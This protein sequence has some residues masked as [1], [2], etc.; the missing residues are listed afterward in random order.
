LLV[1]R[2]NVME[3]RELFNVLVVA[4]LQRSVQRL[5]VSTRNHTAA[6]APTTATTIQQ[7]H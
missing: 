2:S 1:G 5:A 6:L 3:E 4:H 7:C